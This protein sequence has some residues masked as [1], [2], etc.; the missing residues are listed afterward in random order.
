M[1]KGWLYCQP[2]RRFTAPP[3]L[4]GRE[5]ILF[6][7]L[8]REARSALIFPFQVNSDDDLSDHEM[9]SA[10]MAVLFSQVSLA[11]SQDE[12][13]ALIGTAKMLLKLLKRFGMDDELVL[14]ETKKLIR[15]AA[16]RDSKGNKR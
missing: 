15:A 1:P 14:E 8:P 10:V 4:L 9:A 5:D 12:S 13:E 7:I 2:S 16:V 3:Q 6:P 11:R